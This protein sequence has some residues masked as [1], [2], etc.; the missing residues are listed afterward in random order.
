MPTLFGFRQ[1]RFVFSR[2]F[3][4][5]EVLYKKV[6]EVQT[7]NVIKSELSGYSFRI[8]NVPKL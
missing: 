7:L 1:S 8:R 2:I 4:N 3:K 5:K 6:E